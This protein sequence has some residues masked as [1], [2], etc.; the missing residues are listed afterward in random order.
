MLRPLAAVV[1]ALALLPAAAQARPH[2]PRAHV[3]LG[4]FGNLGRIQAL[5]GQQT[6]VG[7]VIVGW[8]LTTLSRIWPALGPTPMLGFTTADAGGEAISPPASRADG[9]T[10]SCSSSAA[11][12]ASSAGRCTSA[13]SA[14]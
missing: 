10:R 14:R 2:T 8:G 4:V 7:H 5:T 3:Q 11:R 1:A 13:R 6:N 12:R 9:A